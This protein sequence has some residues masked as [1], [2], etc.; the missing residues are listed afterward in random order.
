MDG[1]QGLVN[2]AKYAGVGYLAKIIFHGL[3]DLGRSMI[4]RPP[5]HVPIVG[6]PGS[7]AAMTSPDALPGI[8]SVSP[9]DFRNEVCARIGLTLGFY[10]PVTRAARVRCPLLIQICERDNVAPISAAESVVRKVD[11]P[12]EIVRYA[13]GHFDVYQAPWFERSSGDQIEFLRQQLL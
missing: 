7:V 11:G 6:A 9:P 13:C 8:M 12:A 5:W 4:G 10:R 3:R 2:L 1:R